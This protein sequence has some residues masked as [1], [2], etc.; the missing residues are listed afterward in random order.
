MAN[1]AYNIKDSESPTQLH[2]TNQKN[3]STQVNLFPLCLPTFHVSDHIISIKA[4]NCQTNVCY[5]QSSKGWVVDR[6]LFKVL[7]LTFFQL[8]IIDWSQFLLNVKKGIIF[9]YLWGVDN[10]GKLK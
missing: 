8:S 10:L 7:R 2:E 5:C 9:E 3:E 6:L 4:F 1:D